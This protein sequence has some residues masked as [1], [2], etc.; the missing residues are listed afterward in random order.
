VAKL[1]AEQRNP[2]IGAGIELEGD[3]NVTVAAGRRHQPR[4]RGGT[5]VERS[6]V[7]VDD[8][9]GGGKTLENAVKRRRVI[10]AAHHRLRDVHV[11][12]P[13]KRR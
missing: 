10:A 13:E 9:I 8:Q 4:R 6:A 5:A 2:D 11:V 12:G 1:V 7:H 3:A